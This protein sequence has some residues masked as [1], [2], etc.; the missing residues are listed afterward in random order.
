[1]SNAPPIV[2]GARRHALHKPFARG[3]GSRLVGALTRVACA[4][5]GC[6]ASS[7]PSAT[8]GGPTASRS[9]AIAYGTADTTHTA[10][11][12]VLAPVGTTELEE[13]TGTIVQVENGNGFVLTA[14]HCCNTYVPTV[15]VAS[16]NYAVGEQYV[17]G[18]TPVP[19]VYGVVPS[20]VYYDALY[21]GA[22]HD[23]CMLQ[24]SG[25]TTSTPTIALPSSSGDGLELGSAVE[26]VGYGE[27]QTST[28]NTLRRTGTD[29]INDALTPL[30]VAFG[31]GG[32]DDVPGTCDG[33]SGG[34]SLFPAGVAQSEQVVVAVQSYG[35]ATT[36]AAETLGVG[37][38]V[39]SEIG[40]GA[41]ITSY[42]ANAPVGI[43]A[44]ADGG[45]A[46]TD[47]GPGGTD[48]G[49]G[50]TDAGP[51]LSPAPA[52]AARG[53]VLAAMAALLLGLGCKAST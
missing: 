51:G 2:R 41:F 44:G 19:P 38:R 20:S 46:G 7:A 43:Q 36:C 13:C 31:Q 17:L 9:G 49:A 47:G 14:A 8:T 34:P 42:L 45:P 24:F 15:I 21:D 50:G 33:D 32:A 6:T 22:D 28:T 27:T 5:L 30:I 23:F 37:S 3:R 40:P 18:G 12:A 26:H 48:A 39:I 25:A 10:V 52:P 1:M 35:N 16:E 29:T 53:W 11:V 4:L